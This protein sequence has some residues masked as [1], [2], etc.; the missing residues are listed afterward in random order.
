MSLALGCVERVLA[1]LRALPL[2]QPA[3]RPLAN[4]WLIGFGLWFGYLRACSKSNRK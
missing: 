1:A 4:G 2:I 3:I